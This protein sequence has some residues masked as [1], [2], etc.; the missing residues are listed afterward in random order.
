MPMLEPGRLHEV[1]VQGDDRAAGMVF[2]LCR[3]R[4]RC[5]EKVLL[6][7]SGGSLRFCGEGLALMG[8]DPARCTFVAVKEERD[9]LRA[10]LEAARC[11]DVA[12]VVLETRGRFAGYDL[13]AGRR[14]ALAAG[15]SGACII[16]LRCDAPPRSSVAWTRWAVTGAPSVPL[17]TDAP[18]WPAMEAELL[19]WR[20][21]PSGGRWRLEWDAD[22]G[23]FRETDRA[24]A[25]VSGAVV[26][27]SCVREGGDGDRKRSRAA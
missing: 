15:Q 13:T 21:G 27:L 20:G 2:A 5:G 11:P 17:E 14:L 18:G 6:V 7:R 12:Q 19:R 25:P 23:T 4:E 10:G 22:H 26:P 24:P 8:I 1:F 16:V 9:L 3:D